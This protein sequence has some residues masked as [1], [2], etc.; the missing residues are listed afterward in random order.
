MA[1][2]VTG[3]Q[4]KDIINTSLTEAVVS[5][6]MVHVASTIVDENLVGLTPALSALT[7]SNIEMYLAAHFVALT[8]ERG[9]LIMSNFGDSKESLANIYSEGFGT[10]R[11]GQAAMTIDT[12]GVLTSVGSTKMKAE[13]RVV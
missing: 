1:Y 10:T 7:R 4:I 8:E 6:R 2:R 5:Q 9:G 12:S 3:H 11:Y 13:F